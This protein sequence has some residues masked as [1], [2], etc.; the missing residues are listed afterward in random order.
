MRPIVLLG[1]LAAAMMCFEWRALAQKSGGVLKI[2]PPRQ[3]RPAP[4]HEEATN[5]DGPALMEVST[6]GTL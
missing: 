6:T 5:F 3:T 2:V 1:G 4:D